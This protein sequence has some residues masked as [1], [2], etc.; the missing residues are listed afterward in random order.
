MKT[1]LKKF[2]G[3][4]GDAVRQAP[5]YSNDTQGKHREKEQMS[6]PQEEFLDSKS[7]N[8]KN[9]RSSEGK[10]TRVGPKTSNAGT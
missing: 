10:E 9:T 5:S 8:T 3:R 7:I 6:Q 1:A 2:F 4:V